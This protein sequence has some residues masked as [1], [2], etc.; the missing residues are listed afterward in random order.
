MV[1]NRSRQLSKTLN[2]AIEAENIKE[3][4]H[5]E[6]KAHQLGRGRDGT[7]NQL[8]IFYKDIEIMIEN[9]GYVPTYP[10]VIV[11]EWSYESELGKQLLDFY[12]SYKELC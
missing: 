5:I 4:L 2:F 10:R 6:L 11:D 7:I 1:Y 12:E 3:K 9:K 8:K